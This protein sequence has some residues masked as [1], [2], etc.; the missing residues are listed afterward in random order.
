MCRTLTFKIIISTCCISSLASSQASSQL[1]SAKSP[2]QT[3]NPIHINNHQVPNPSAGTSSH[4]PLSPQNS[5]QSH[6]SEISQKS[7][8]ISNDQGSLVSCLQP[9][10]NP[11]TSNLP[12][13]TQTTSTPAPASQIPPVSPVS[14][15]NHNSA[16]GS[17]NSAAMR[18]MTIGKPIKFDNPPPSAR[19]TDLKQN[20]SKRFGSEKIKMEDFRTVAVLGRGHFGK[21]LLG[22]HKYTKKIYAIKALKKA[23]IY[24]RDEVDSL[25]CEKRIL[26]ICT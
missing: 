21:V 12:C 25:M 23:D 3:Q 20:I 19:Q 18:T 8:K 6:L 11:C 22:E 7:Q 13:A 16:Q 26:E 2:K 5:H 24:A 1:T 10:T 4:Q 9:A 14:S 15:K 17:P